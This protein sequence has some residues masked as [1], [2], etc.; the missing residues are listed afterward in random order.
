VYNT[1]MNI[2]FCKIPK[3]YQSFLTQ[4][5]HDHTCIFTDD[6]Q[7]YPD[8]EDIDGLG[9]YV[10]TE[11]RSDDINSFP[12]LK[13]ITTIST[14][15]DHI[16]VA[17][18]ESKNITVTNVP[19]YGA[20]SVSEFTFGLLLTLARNIHRAYP[21]LQDHDQAINS[22]SYLGI[23]LYGKTLGVIG[24]GNIGKQVIAIAQG[25]GMKVVAYDAFPDSDFAEQYNIDY[26]DLKYLLS[27]SDIVTLHVPYL[28][29]TRHIISHK[30]LS[31]M[32]PHAL[33]INTAR[34]E[35]VHS[36]D[37]IK[38]LKEKTIKGAA[39]DVLEGERG[40]ND[41]TLWAN[42][43][44][45]EAQEQI[46]TMLID[47]ELIDMPNVIVTPHIASQTKE[48]RDALYHTTVKNIR[49]FTENN[50]IN[51]VRK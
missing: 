19:G 26:V 29:E 22:N 14:G 39:F 30:E 20:H 3:H 48:A 37:V 38:A 27:H 32:Q 46:R 13:L 50:S 35:L 17:Y 31:L 47:H 8:K 7:S 5:L 4:E 11:V 25:F 16:D 2:L 36:L 23:T 51:I 10:Q 12:N 40:L 18:A 9:V 45:E 28:P 41:P 34:G 1:G 15:Y 42:I 44:N 43:N 21:D 33:L 49:A 24:T 6:I